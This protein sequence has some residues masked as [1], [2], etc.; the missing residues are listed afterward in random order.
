MD[1]GRWTVDDGRWTVGTL[2][3]RYGYCIKVFST[4]QTYHDIKIEAIFVN[5]DKTQDFYN[6]IEYTTNEMKVFT[7]T[8][9]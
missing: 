3:E 1:D 4:D 8:G 6:Y 5:H 2:K 7:L 9:D